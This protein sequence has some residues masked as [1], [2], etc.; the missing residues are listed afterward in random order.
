MTFVSVVLIFMACIAICYFIF[1]YRRRQSSIKTVNSLPGPKTFPLIGSAFYLLQRRPDEFLDTIIELAETYSSPLRFWIGNKLFIGINKPD[2]IQTILQNSRCLNKSVL[3]EFVEPV[4]GKGLLT[5]PVSIWTE[6][7][8]MIAPSFN[9]NMLQKFFDIFVEQSLIFTKKLEKVGLNGNEVF[10]LQHIAECFQTIACATMTDVKV[11]YLSN[12]ISQF[13]KLLMSGKETI[14][15]RMQNIFLYPNF[16]FNLT[17]TGREQRKCINI[18]HSSIDEIMQQ[19]IYALNELNTKTKNETS[20]KTLLHILMEASYKNKCT[21]EMIRDN[22]ITTLIAATDT[23]AITITFVVLMLANFPDIQE[24]VYEEL[25]E[26]Y[27]T[28][29]PKYAPIKYEDLQHMNYLDRVIKETM[30]IFPAVPVIGRYLTED[31]QM[32]DIILPKGSNVIIG[33]FI[34]HRDE[35]YWPNPLVFDPD[36]FLPERIGTSYKHYMPFSMGPRN[37][38]GI[39]YAM[40]SMKVML[41][42]LIRTFMFKVDKSIEIDKIKLNLDILLSTVEPIKV[43]IEKR[44]LH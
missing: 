28:K 27:G 23:T 34:L 19:Q 33:L 32:G 22:M 3:Y 14:K 15:I 4:L 39:N 2:Q 17:A 35:K 21:Q 30:R 5:A 16:I 20:H 6:H 42:T 38:I 37:C 10:F 1:N 44:N 43:K 40:I 31:T 24:K 29:T 7:R 36:R 25:R 12:R 11:E 13:F 26:I 18:L 8:K 9:T 41:A